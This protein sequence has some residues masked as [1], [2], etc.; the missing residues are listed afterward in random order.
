[1]WIGGLGCGPQP[2]CM[3]AV[4]IS[5]SHGLASRYNVKMGAGLMGKLLK[6]EKV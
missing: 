6:N 4:R 2:Q 1:M 5:A 3:N